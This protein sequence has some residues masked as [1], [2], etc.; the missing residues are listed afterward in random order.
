M[1]GSIDLTDMKTE[2]ERGEKR[3]IFVRIVG[4]EAVISTN[5]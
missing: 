1:L 2:G 4:A 5:L 3:E